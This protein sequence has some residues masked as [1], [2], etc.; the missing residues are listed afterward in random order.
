M[1]TSAFPQTMKVQP[2]PELIDLYKERTR[3]TAKGPVT[4]WVKKNIQEQL[5]TVNKSLGTLLTS[6]RETQAQAENV[7]NALQASTDGASAGIG[8]GGILL[9]A[10]A[11]YWIFFRKH[12]R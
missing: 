8:L 2:P 1:A 12:R 10:G 6:Q 4:D 11:A 3:F 5:G 7:T 9:I